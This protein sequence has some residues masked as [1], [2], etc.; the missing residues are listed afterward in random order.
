MAVAPSLPQ[1]RAC[2]IGA[3]VGRRTPRRGRVTVDGFG[4][5]GQFAG[6][7]MRTAVVRGVFAAIIS[8]HQP[9]PPMP[10]A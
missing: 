2:R 7:I 8:T 6:T 3:L 10:G 9:R 1:A 4:V 5:W